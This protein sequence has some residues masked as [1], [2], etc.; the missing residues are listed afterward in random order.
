MNEVEKFEAMVGG[1][2]LT[3]KKIDGTEEKI[4]VRQV[5]IRRMAQYAVAIQD[6]GSLAKLFTEKDDQWIDS[7][8]P[9]SF[10]QIVEE[11]ERL[12]SFFFARW[13]A[14]QNARAEKLLP[15][16]QEQRPSPTTLPN[17]ASKPV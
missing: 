13:I 12:N 5:P 15:A 4:K 9:E 3:V 8:T 17:V 1:V 10:E 6:E 2:E 7:L 16:L 14:R 11:G